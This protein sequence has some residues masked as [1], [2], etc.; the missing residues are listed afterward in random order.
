MA[1]RAKTLKK[2]K[3]T[4]TGRKKVISN[5]EMAMNVIETLVTKIE[6]PDWGAV[7]ISKDLVRR[8]IDMPVEGV[9]ATFEFLKLSK[10]NSKR[11]T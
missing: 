2:A 10:K 4:N 7:E 5:R 9:E 11:E 8:G 3:K 6:H 1:N